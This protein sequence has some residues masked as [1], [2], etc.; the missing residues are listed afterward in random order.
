MRPFAETSSW[1]RLGFGRAMLDERS[2]VDADLGVAE[3]GLGADV[4]WALSD[5][6]DTRWGPWVRGQTSD[7]KTHSAHGGLEL[8]LGGLPNKLRMFHYT[9]E[10]YALVQLGGGWTGGRAGSRPTLSATVTWG[11]RAPFR[12]WKRL[13]CD[14]ATFDRDLGARRAA[15]RYMIGARLYT[16]AQADPNDLGYWQWTGGLEFEPVGALRYLLGMY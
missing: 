9:G 8:Y 5:D 6:G 4:T 11:Y 16:S 13:S 15:S 3:L 1:V 7:F 10:G 14:R 2:R 12:L